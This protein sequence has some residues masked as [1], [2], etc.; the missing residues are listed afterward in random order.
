MQVY[1]EEG[2]NMVGSELFQ[3]ETGRSREWKEHTGWK[4]E[5]TDSKE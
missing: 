3:K 1:G 4:S 2:E 5:M